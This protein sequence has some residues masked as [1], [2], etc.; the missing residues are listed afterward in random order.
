MKR[1]LTALSSAFGLSAIAAPDIKTVDPKTLY[2]SLATINDALPAID[3]A[4]K[5]CTTDLVI[6]ED[7]WRQFEA[8][9]RTFDAT[10][11]EELAAVQRIFKEKS[12]ST[13]DFRVFSEIHVRKQIAQP[14]SAPLAWTELLAES[15]ANP[16]SVSGVGLRVQG[17][18]RDG[19]SFRVGQLTIFGRRHGGNVDVLCFAATQS[20]SL[21]E[22]EAQRLAAFIERNNLVVV[23]WPSATVLKDKAALMNFL[24]QRPEKKG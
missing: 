11:K 23:H 7:D 12:K 18:I 10:M 4:A 9:S 22:H 17:L 16:G 6:H 15:G 2:F 20:P 3:P 13:G 1:F 24:V 21:S 14:L 5:P 19:F 8:V